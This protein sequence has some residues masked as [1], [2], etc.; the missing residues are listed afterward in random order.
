MIKKHSGPNPY[1]MIEKILAGILRRNSGNEPEEECLPPETLALL[2]EGKLAGR[3]KDRALNHL[4]QCPECYDNS[5]FSSKLNRE[6]ET[7]EISRPKPALFRPLALAASLAIVIFSIYILYRTGNLPGI[8]HSSGKETRATAKPLAV[9]EQPVFHREKAD[10]ESVTRKKAEIRIPE[11]EKKSP[12]RKMTDEKDASTS[13]GRSAAHRQAAGKNLPGTQRELEIPRPKKMEETNLAAAKSKKGGRELQS[14]T[15]KQNEEIKIQAAEDMIPE[16]AA[17]ASEPA[18]TAARLRVA[19]EEAGKKGET[20]RKSM[21][22]TDMAR[23]K[24]PTQSEVVSRYPDGRTRTVN[25]Y[26][27][28]NERK[29]LSEIIEYNRQGRIISITNLLNNTLQKLGYFPNGNKKFIENYQNH[30]PHGTWIK[31]DIKG[32]IIEKTL[33]RNGK[34]VEQKPAE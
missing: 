14:R 24:T 29:V 25:N 7:L 4:A 27:K 6:Q 18:E 3:E 30:K 17:K 10:Q 13:M 12:A 1:P 23:V 9:P 11:T 16:T 19:G 8:F 2:V 32:N 15:D 26:R 28:D 34:T 33:Y 31:W 21:I 20:E 22:P 5:L